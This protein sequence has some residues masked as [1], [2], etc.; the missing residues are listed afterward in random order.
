MNTAEPKPLI[1]VP[2]DFSPLAFYAME[3]GANMSKAMKCHM[4]ILHVVARENETQAMTRKM[5]FVAEDCFV[6]FDVR[7]DVIVRQGNKP[8]PVIKEV[9][10][11]ISPLLVILKTDGGVNT[12]K[13]LTGTSTPFLVIQGEPKRNVIDNISFPINFL[14]KNEEKLKRLLHF[15]EYFPNAVMHIITPSG[16]GMGKE[17]LVSGNISITKKVLDNQ[18][19]KTNFITHDKSKNTAEV[20][21]ELSKDMDMIV[22]QIEEAT[23]LNKF[24]FGLR[25][26]KLIINAD[27]IPILCFNDETDLKLIE[28]NS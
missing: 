26:E 11:E 15:N 23:W 22:I 16:K 8:Y 18:G 14:L 3:H 27:K 13:I 17:R 2:C 20:I 1:L 7:P 25:E 4:A 19:V 5:H 6:K 21:L 12:I 28:S 9:T 24:L 10:N